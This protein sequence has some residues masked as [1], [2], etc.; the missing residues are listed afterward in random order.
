M[1]CAGFDSISFGPLIKSESAFPPSSVSTWQRT[2]VPAEK[3]E[4]INWQGAGVKNKPKKEQG[5]SQHGLKNCR[6]NTPQ[7]ESAITQTSTVMKFKS[8]PET[9]FKIDVQSNYRFPVL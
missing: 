7:K 5:K 6:V 1:H 8:L 2:I 4:F 3:E 9:S